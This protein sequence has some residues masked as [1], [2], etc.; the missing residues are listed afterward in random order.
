MT[1]GYGTSCA[2]VPRTGLTRDEEAQHGITAEVML[3]RGWMLS[4][5]NV[6]IAMESLCLRT[7]SDRECDRRAEL[8]LT[9]T[10]ARFISVL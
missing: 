6:V 2:I 1:A 8:R 4:V 9:Y 10:R 3:G 5:V 7:G